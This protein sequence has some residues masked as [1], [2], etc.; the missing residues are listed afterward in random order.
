MTD[1]IPL[2]PLST[3]LFPVGR[4]SL[5]IFEPRY[6]DLVS[7]CLKSDSGFGVVWLREGSEVQ[8]EGSA[9][10]PKLAQIGSYARIVDWDSLPNGL[11]GL[12]IEGEKKFR[13]ISSSQR[14]DKL[15]VAEIEWIEPEPI[16]DLSEQSDDMHSILSQLLEHPHIERLKLAPEVNDVST[17]SLLLAQLLPI[18]EAI[19]F[20]LLSTDEPISRL[21]LLAKLL[22]E[23]NE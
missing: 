16:I 6:L 2:F 4:M 8:K 5:Q 1:T 19:K 23:Y 3:V 17:L 22:E 20:D 15:H 10:N 12:T 21:E 7:S 18:D 11:L 9:F 13:L 14:E